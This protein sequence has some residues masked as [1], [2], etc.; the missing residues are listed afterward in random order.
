MDPGKGVRNSKLYSL[1]IQVKKSRLWVKIDFSN[2]NSGKCHSPFDWPWF[3]N[4][5]L[6][7]IKGTKIVHTIEMTVFEID[8]FLSF[9]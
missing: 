7:K 2:Q 3:M 1:D 4:L 8:N 9:N 5:Q 6:K